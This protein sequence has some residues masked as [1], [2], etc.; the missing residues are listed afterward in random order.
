MAGTKIWSKMGYTGDAKREYQRQWVAERRLKGLN[1]LGG[2]CVQ[3]GSSEKLEVDHKDPSSKIS[4]RIWS[5]SWQR[6]EDEL[7]KC[8]LLCR[9]CHIR[10]TEPEHP[11]GEKTPQ[12]RLTNEQV[13]EI[14]KSTEKTRILSEQYG[15]GMRQIQYIRRGDQWK[16]LS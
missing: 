11:K 8:Q 1:L 2:K 13:C 14:L 5:W 3:C 12:A 10:K 15:V 4:H 16:H 9:A 6:I 7:S